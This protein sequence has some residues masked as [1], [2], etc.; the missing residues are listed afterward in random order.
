MF[1]ELR[2]KKSALSE[3]EC[4]DI[5]MRQKRGI[6]SLIGD[7]G[8]P[9][10]IPMNHYYSVSEG[11]IY[12]HCGRAGHKIDAIKSCDKASF[13]VHDEG[14]AEAGDWALNVKSVIA[15]GK[16]KFVEDHDYALDICRKLTL[17][18]TDDEEYIQRELRASGP[19]VLCLKFEIEHISGKLVHEG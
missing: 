19:Y 1:R 12:F 18:F 16:I 8:Y 9:Y 13:C 6:L 2:R 7:E 5:L 10:G 11:C 14:Y 4:L 15:F 17:K 3:S